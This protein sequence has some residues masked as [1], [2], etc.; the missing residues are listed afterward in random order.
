MSETTTTAVATTALTPPQT[1]LLN[2]LLVEVPKD[3]QLSWLQLGKSKGNVRT[4]MENKSLELQALLLGYEKLDVSSLQVQVDLYKKGLGDLPDIRK[5]FTKYL[6]AIGS[7]LMEVQRTAESWSM[8]EDAKGRLLTLKL[9]KEKKDNEAGGKTREQNNFRTHVTNEYV[10]IRT[11]YAVTLDKRIID[12]YEKALGEELTEDGLRSRVIMV[13]NMLINMPVPSIVRFSGTLPAGYV[14]LNTAEEL[15][16]IGA[17]IPVPDYSSILQARITDMRD[18]FNLYFSD[19]QN[20]EAA[21]AHLKQI[22]AQKDEAAQKQSETEKGINT[23]TSKVTGSLS[24]SSM[25]PLIK[26]REIVMKETEDAWAFK[27]ITEFA[28][29]FDTCRPR[30]KIQSWAKLTLAQMVKCLQEEP[31]EIAGLEYKETV[32]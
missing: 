19:K 5:G 12:E 11:D 4:A 9:E 31:G 7:E 6:D 27:V 15:G 17:Q 18:K 23:L 30:L 1:E 10:R 24:F 3:R 29:R 8:Y 26:K 21:V 22:Q 20:K 28:A 32:K 14:L 2:K 13:E 16:A 25:K